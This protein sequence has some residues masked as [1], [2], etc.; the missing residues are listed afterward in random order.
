MNVIGEKEIRKYRIWSSL[1]SEYLP[2]LLTIGEL[3]VNTN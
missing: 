3:S 1:N 2:E